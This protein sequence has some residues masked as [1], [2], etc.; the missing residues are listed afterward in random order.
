[1]GSTHTG[2]ASDRPWHQVKTS[3]G[4]PIRATDSAARNSYPK[5]SHTAVLMSIARMRPATRRNTQGDNRLAG[6]Q[7]HSSALY[8]QHNTQVSSTAWARPTAGLVCPWPIRDKKVYNMHTGLGQGR[9]PM[10]CSPTCP[11]NHLLGVAPG[12]G[13]HDLD[14]TRSP[15]WTLPIQEAP[16]AGQPLECMPSLSS[17]DAS[18]HQ[19][20]SV[21]RTP[22]QHRLCFHVLDIGHIEACH[23]GA[24]PSKL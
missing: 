12:Q 16:G 3:L 14:T 6:H 13:G 5:A 15:S 11:S 21:S 7:H 19:H 22:R 20:T 24:S 4:P 18:D 9:H 8:P 17:R 2:E 10:D 1:M 23:R